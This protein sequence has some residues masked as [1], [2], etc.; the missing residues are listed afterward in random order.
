MD[1]RLSIASCKKIVFQS[2]L[3]ISYFLPVL[4]LVRIY[5]EAYSADSKFIADLFLQPNFAAAEEL[6]FKTEH[7]FKYIISITFACQQNYENQNQ[8]IL[9]C[10]NFSRTHPS[11]YWTMQS[12]QK[13]FC[14]ERNYRSVLLI[15]RIHNFL[16]QTC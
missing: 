11:L 14:H 13:T 10:A 5:N 4:K 8:F 15:C 1:S 9:V 12:C 16:Q 6:Q 3:Y 2:V 7:I